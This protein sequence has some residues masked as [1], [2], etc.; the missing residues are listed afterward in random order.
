MRKLA[1]DVIVGVEAGTAALRAVQASD[2]VSCTLRPEA[3]AKSWARAGNVTGCNT[4][5]PGALARVDA[6][7]LRAAATM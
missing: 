4:V 7:A 2:S 6:V 5:L 3:S 1:V